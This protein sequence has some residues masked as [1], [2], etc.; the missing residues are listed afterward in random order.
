MHELTIVEGEAMTIL[1]AMREAVSRGW[2]NIM[3]ESDST[4]VVDAIHSNCQGSQHQYRERQSEDRSPE[5][6]CESFYDAVDDRK[7]ETNLHR[8][9]GLRQQQLHASNERRH[10]RQQVEYP[11]RNGKRTTGDSISV[12]TKQNEGEP[13]TGLRRHDKTGVES[14]KHQH[15]VEDTYLALAKEGGDAAEGVKVGAVMVRLGGR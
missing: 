7:F 9:A 15:S 11:S 10:R 2:T 6:T 1:H 5:G 14:Q 12:T 3:F 4:I 8:S 13:V